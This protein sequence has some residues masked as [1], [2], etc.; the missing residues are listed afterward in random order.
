[1]VS[2]T[3]ATPAL[4][5]PSTSD[6]ALAEQFFRDGRALLKENKV[7]EACA[8]FGESQRLDPQTGTLLNL[9]LCH[10]Q[11]GK[12]AS[13]WAEFGEVAEQAERAGDAPR[14]TFARQHVKDLDGKLSR[15][16]L[17]VER[18]AADETIRID[19]RALGASAWAAALPLDPGEHTLEASASGRKTWSSSVRIDPG[20]TIRELPVPAL[21][22]ATLAAQPAVPLAAPAATGPAP[23]ALSPA[24]PETPSG[25]GRPKTL[26]FVLGGVGLAG[27][28][29][30]S[31]FGIDTFSKNSSINGLCP[32]KCPT[33]TALDQSKTLNSQASTSALVSTIGFGVGVA[34]L[35]AGAY[36]LFLAPPSSA[37][38]AGV[39][40]V[41]SL[42]PATKGL[43][44]VGRW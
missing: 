1:L 19:G 2:S 13:A 14:A 38:T 42:D 16:R 40:V 37:T 28:A 33:P 36:F 25:G 12:T 22:E 41:P 43:G 18:P 35:A 30:G 8:R 15:V 6:K 5:Q 21:E 32:D 3:V 31:V 29:V 10:E 11:E 44:V 23:G 24:S 26:G 20:A 39:R 27:I 34:G 9:A 4:A 7:G 17:R